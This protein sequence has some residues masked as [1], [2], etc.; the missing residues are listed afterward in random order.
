MGNDYRSGKKASTII[1]L[2]T[3][4]TFHSIFLLPI[5]YTPFTLLP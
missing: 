4:F 3:A 5:G 1:L 2:S